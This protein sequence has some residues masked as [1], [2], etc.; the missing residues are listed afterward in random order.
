MYVYKS[1]Q[2]IKLE[3]RT[4]NEQQ[5]DGVLFGLNVRGRETSTKKEKRK[6]LTK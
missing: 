5:K 6:D 2:R 1:K 4:L 3:K